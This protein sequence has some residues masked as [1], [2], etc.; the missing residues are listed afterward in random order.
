MTKKARV[1][2]PSHAPVTEDDAW[3]TFESITNTTGLAGHQ[4]AAF[5]H[6]ILNMIPHVIREAQDIVLLD[7]DNKEE[8]VISVCNVSVGQPSVTEVNGA[9]TALTPFQARTRGLTY[10]SNV[11]VDVCHDIY[12]FE[13]GSRGA[14]KERRVF[15]EVLLCILPVM[16][17]SACCYTRLDT[18]NE[19][20][21]DCGGYFIINGV[22]KA[23][24]AQERLRTNAPFVFATKNN[25]KYSY[26][27]ELRS[28]HEDKLRSTSTLLIYITTTKRGAM[29]EMVAHLPFMTQV[30]VPV[31]AL[32]R[33]LRVGTRAD[34]IKLITGDQPVPETRLLCSI[35]DND[36]TADMCTSDLF[37]WLGRE[38]TV[39]TT[40]EKRQRFLDHIVS[41]ELIPH[42]G[43]D[44]SP[45]VLQKKAA[46]LGFMVRKLIK[47]YIGELQ[48]DD[49]D[50][51]SLKR[52]D[53]NSCGLLFRQLYR[54]MVKS[55]S[56]QLQRLRDQGKL[57]FTNVSTLF[58][59]K[60]IT[61]TFRHAFSTGNWGMTVGNKN[62][63]TA[64]SSQQT[65]VAQMISKLSVVSMYSNMRRI[66]TPI[67]REGKAP[68]PRQLHY[69]TWGIICCVETPEGSSCGLVKHL[70]MLTHVRMST[71][72]SYIIDQI[73]ATC[74]HMYSDL[75]SVSDVDR[76]CG[77]PLLING[78]LF[79]YFPTYV[80]GESFVA[81]MRQL[82]QQDN[83]PFDTTIALI[84][85]S[86]VVDTDPGCLLRPVFVGE[87]MHKVKQI[88]MEAPDLSSVRSR[89]L[90][91]G[92]V[93]YVDKQE[94]HSMR[95]GLWADQPNPDLYT[96][97]E[98]HP[99][100]IL[101][102]CAAVIPFPDHNQS[103]RNVYQA[104][105]GKQAIG[106]TAFNHLSRLDTI[107][108]T[109]CEAQRPLVSTR[110]DKILNISDAPAGINVIVAI[111]VR[112]GYNQEDSV[113][114]NKSAIE[115]GLFRSVKYCTMRDEERANGADSEK[116]E[117][118]NQTDGIAGMRVGN[119][120]KLEDAGV[121]PVGSVVSS[122]DAIIGKTVATTSADA[123]L[124]GTR[125]TIKRDKSVIL[126]SETSVVD[127]VMRSSKPDGS[128][129]IKVK[130]R[131]TRSPQVG[132][133]F[134]SRMGQKGVCGNQFVQDDMPYTADGLTPDILVNPHAI[135][136]RMTLG[137]LL[138]CLLGKLSAVRGEEGDGTPFCG[139]SVE[140]I[141][142]RLAA[143][144]L[145][146]FGNEVLYDGT[147]GEAFEAK[148]FIGPTYYQRLKHMAGDKVHSRGRGPRQVLTH[149]PLEGRS[150]D[151]GL[152]L[153]E[154][155]RDCILAHGT[156]EFLL[157]RLM[158]AS[159]AFDAHICA[160]C[161]NFAMPAAQGT[162]V[163]N[164]SAFCRVCSSSRNV[165]KITVPYAAKL[166]IQELQGMHVSTQL[167]P[168]AAAS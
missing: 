111:M 9:E 2:S 21:M 56:L 100:A 138:E 4:I 110:I 64:A 121:L 57:K 114:L 10:A 54:S 1:V 47:V 51:Y 122:G 127:A 155:E 130:T 67:A 31:L 83:I 165:K 3:G 48:V 139:M 94:E 55:V 69:T 30:P 70:A 104:A 106:I 137:Q 25:S 96:H 149:Q 159:D 92:A 65:G 132:D 154:M 11:V 125:K 168:E 58:A 20:R 53:P 85:G 76:G 12:V 107:S 26:V 103:P 71:H 36:T 147:T 160:S 146:P 91:A 78:C 156:H 164:R 44:N 5:D 167:I 72:S 133:K 17:R 162:L 41:N 75:E 93:V 13:N 50:H 102:V 116:F 105:M 24:I 19:C 120:E 77:V 113:I 82:R 6:F 108:H 88:I 95:I 28:C 145:D 115:R 141:G 151:G 35:L 161:G 14:Q 142:E 87:N 126:K 117:N 157:E 148:V 42:M 89:L 109:L 140:A 23:I 81:Y 97:Y 52:I 33:L 68:K 73:E 39:E 119:Y 38:A 163:R 37:D 49:R 143:E 123:I 29:P 74:K 99:C 135:P 8:H 34:V 27:C 7:E 144:G 66:N 45:E 22:E 134:S 40:K 86:V 118:P 32:F 166:L 63:T 158:F 131:N 18:S 84:D 124:K 15:R 90:A 128:K 62:S 79:G 59:G 80:N 61:N 150:R 112:R 152:R 98:I 129:V 101:G 43:L 136:S 60:R 153:G 16:V 46:Y